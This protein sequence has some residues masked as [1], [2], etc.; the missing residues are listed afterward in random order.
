MDR[1]AGVCGVGGGCGYGVVDGVGVGDGVVVVSSG[2]DG[3]GSWRD[4][5]QH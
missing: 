2:G 4:E 1:I 3:V 5:C